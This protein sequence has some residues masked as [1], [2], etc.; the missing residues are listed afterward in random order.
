MS[1]VA[2]HAISVVVGLFFVFF[3][4]LKLAPIFSEE[5]Y[6]ST[7]KVFVKIYGPFLFSRW[8]GWN[9][10]PHLVRRVYGSIEVVGGL[11]LA[12]CSGLV[13]DTSAGILLA[14]ML[15]NLFSIWN[16]SEG[17]K[18]ASNSI[19]FGLLLTCRFVIRVQV[20]KQETDKWVAL[21]FRADNFS[22]PALLPI[23]LTC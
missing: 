5:L 20:S 19:V 17:L 21:A 22:S 9:P 14:L 10:S 18:D 12:A 15:F 16:A 7:R 1:G 13:Q 23:V 2:L 11:T 8:T 6:R 3:G 4:T